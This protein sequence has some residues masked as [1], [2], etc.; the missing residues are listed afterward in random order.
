MK[1]IT[2]EGPEVN[3]DTVSRLSFELPIGGDTIKTSTMVILSEDDLYD[4]KTAH[5]LRGFIID[6]L[7][8]PKRYRSY[9][10]NRVPIYNQIKPC[11]F[12]DDSPTA[13]ITYY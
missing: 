11:L 7:M 9:E 8:I 6:I 4:I 3:K 13:V 12:M 1:I 10:F 2:I 5:K